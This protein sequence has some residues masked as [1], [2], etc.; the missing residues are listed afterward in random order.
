[1][2]DEAS[3]GMGGSSGNPGENSSPLAI[4]KVEVLGFG[5]VGADKEK[6]LPAREENSEED[7]D[8]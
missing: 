1:M 5:A 7:K 4:L 6:G 2:S 8:S 3:A